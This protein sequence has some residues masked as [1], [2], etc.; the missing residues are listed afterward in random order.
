[1][2]KTLGRASVFLALSVISLAA[3]WLVFLFFSPVD[4]AIPRMS[5]RLAEGQAEELRTAVRT[6]IVPVVAA[7]Q[8]MLCVLVRTGLN[9]VRIF[10]TMTAVFAALAAL[11]SSVAKL[12]GY[13]DFTERAAVL[14]GHVH[15]TGWGIAAFVVEMLSF[16]STVIGLLLLYRP[17]SNAYIKH[18]R[19]LRFHAR[20]EAWPRER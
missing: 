17:A 10:L 3:L 18:V 14:G 1:M 13:L 12:L 11:M 4:I 2:P 5:A 6:P 7:V 15:F 9:S 19:L 20:S 16:V 8:V